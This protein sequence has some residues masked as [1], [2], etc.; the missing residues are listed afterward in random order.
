M[1]TRKTLRHSLVAAAA[2]VGSLGL[3]SCGSDS[4]STDTT[5]AATAGVVIEGAWARTSAAGADMGAAY[6]SITSAIDD[7]LTDVKVDP[8]VAEMAQ[9]HEVV[10]A[11]GD[12]TSDNTMMSSDSTAAPEMT[13]Q[14]VDEIALNAGEKVELKPGGYHIMLMK[15]AKPLESGSTISITLVFANAGEKVVEVP[16]REDAP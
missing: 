10:M 5:A 8:A 14:E 13:M 7:R 12:M 1:K 3:A 11:G 15:L 4:D 2:L 6:M 9:I 16:V